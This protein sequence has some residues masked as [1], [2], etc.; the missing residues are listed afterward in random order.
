MISRN[1]ENFP[2]YSDPLNYKP[3]EQSIEDWAE[4]PEVAVTNLMHI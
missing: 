3:I 2:E 4:V 1:P